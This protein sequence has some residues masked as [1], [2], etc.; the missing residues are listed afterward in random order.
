MKDLAAWTT[1]ETA[2]GNPALKAEVQR[3]GNAELA[4]CLD[5]S[6]TI[7]EMVEKIVKKVP[8]F[9][10]VRQSLDL[11]KGKADLMVVSATPGEA[12]RREWAEHGIAAHMGLIAGQEM[13]SKAE[14]LKHAAGGKYPPEKVLMVGDAPGDLKAARSNQALFFPVNPGAEEASWERF[15]QEAAPRFLAGRYTRQYERGLVAEF[16][17]I[18]PAE[19]PWKKAE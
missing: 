9:P 4:R 19:P 13:G 6:T 8:P 2:L 5:W 7:N 18:L 15:H 3:T 12:L 1:R 16:E 17:K 14:H 10:G 11:L